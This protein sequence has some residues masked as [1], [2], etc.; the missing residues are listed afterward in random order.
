MRTVSVGV[1][2][3]EVEHANT[4]AAASADGAAVRARIAY[5]DRIV[6]IMLKKLREIASCGRGSGLMRKINLLSGVCNSRRLLSTPPYKGN[7]R[8]TGLPG[9]PQIESGASS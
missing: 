2:P 3:E 1:C 7:A 9:Y 5:Y 8:L 4:R 6:R